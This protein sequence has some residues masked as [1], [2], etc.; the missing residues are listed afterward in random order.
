MTARPMSSVRRTVPPAGERGQHEPLLL[1]LVQEPLGLAQVAAV[2]LPGDEQHRRGGEARLE[3]ARHGVGRAR[4][5]AGDDH[6]ELPGGARVAVGGVRGGLLVPYPDRR[7]GAAPRDGVVD[8]QVVDAHDAEDMADAEHSRAAATASRPSSPMVSPVRTRSTPS[9]RCR[10]GH[11][12]CGRPRR[13]RSI[14]SM[15]LSSGATSIAPSAISRTAYRNDSSPGSLTM[16]ALRP[17]CD[18]APRA[19]SVDR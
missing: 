13:P 12:Q 9:A 15:W 2:D 7:D 10:S 19:P 1:G 4:P 3:Q 11:G 17:E 8:R 14:G 16:A 18:C 5:G 6:A